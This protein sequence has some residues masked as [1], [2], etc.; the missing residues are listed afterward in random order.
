MH[1]CGAPS[2]SIASTFG[3]RQAVL[4]R[5]CLGSWRRAI[6]TKSDTLLV[7]A[8]MAGALLW[9]RSQAAFF[10]QD[11]SDAVLA[12]VVEYLAVMTVTVLV[13]LVVSW[14]LFRSK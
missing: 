7:E 13:S 3:P 2:R 10:R 1:Q 12:D 6:P 14:F 4:R 11:M 9:T 8:P 5:Q